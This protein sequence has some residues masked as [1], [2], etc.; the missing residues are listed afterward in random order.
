MLQTV[1]LSL[2]QHGGS[3]PYRTEHME[4]NCTSGPKQF[5]RQEVKGAQ[6]YVGLYM[7]SCVIVQRFKQ[8]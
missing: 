1:S 4:L 3:A 5:C 7:Q 8:N 2:S 6:H